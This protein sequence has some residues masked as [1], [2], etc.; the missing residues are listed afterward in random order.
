MMSPD[1]DHDHDLLA[2]VETMVTLKASEFKA[3]ESLVRSSLSA[4]SYIEN[5]YVASSAASRG[6][7]AE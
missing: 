5:F 7:G 6:R 1:H 2:S 4:L 3:L